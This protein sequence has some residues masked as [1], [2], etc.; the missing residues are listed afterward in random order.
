M[1]FLELFLAR[2]DSPYIVLAP[3]RYMLAYTAISSPKFRMTKTD[4]ANRA[5]ARRSLCHIVSKKKS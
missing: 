2:T 1:T 3:L 4:P 5:T